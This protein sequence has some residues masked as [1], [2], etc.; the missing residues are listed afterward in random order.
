MAVAEPAQAAVAAESVASGFRGPDRPLYADYARCVH[1][2]LCLNHCPTYRLWGLEADSP[3]GRIR[4][5]VLV[6]EGRLPLGESFVRHI[7]QCLDCR[8]CETACPSGVEYG[9]LV[10]GARAQIEQHY[11]RPLLSRVARRLMYRHL[12]PHPGRIAVAARLARFYQRSG[13]Q[14]LA[15]ST[16]LLHLVG[17]A[18][19][20]RL[21]PRIEDHFFFSQLG[22]TFPAQGR[23]RARVALFAG[24]VAQVSFTGLQ[25]ATIR[26]LT[27]NGCEVVVPAGQLCCGA[28]PAHAGVRDVARDLARVNMGVFLRDEFDA[29]LTNAAGCGSM[30]KEYEHLFP[31]EDPAHGQARAFHAKMRDVTEFLSELGLVAPLGELRRRVTY[32]DSCHL[33]HGQKVREAPRR[34]IRSVPG[35]ELVEMRLADHCCGSAGVYNVTQTRTSLD[36]LAEKMQC[37]RQTGADIIVTANPG[38]LLHLRAGAEIHGTGQE[39]LHVVELLD[40]AQAA[41]ISRQ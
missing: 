40:R 35:V 14:T 33:A 39:V 6:D 15:R 23:C 2:G 29:L 25:E 26:V 7:D 24:C 19:R 37:A 8:A 22:R 27:A 12:L 38:C 16:G 1:C 32:Q 30:L 13:L 17:M 20:E 10:E 11:R 21:M 31:A 36:L 4:Q 3:R 18:D 34:L 41:A 9:K 5:M 28:L